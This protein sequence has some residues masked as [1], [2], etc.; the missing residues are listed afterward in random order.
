MSID[1]SNK[2]VLTSS[3]DRSVSNPAWA[4]D[5][6]SIYVQVEDRGI[7]KVERV[8]LDGSIRDIGGG[9]GGGEIDRPYA[10]GDFSVSRNG[11]VALT[12][13]DPLH[14]SDVG[15]AANGSVRRL[16]HLNSSLLD[17]K[18]LAQVQKLPVTSE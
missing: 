1:G 6:R 9:M 17:S 16:T 18:A 12:A 14:P 4:G 3:L 7:N 2:R 15:I 8:G 10:G 5:S 11:V 13:G